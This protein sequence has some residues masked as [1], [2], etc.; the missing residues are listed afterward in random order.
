M[1]EGLLACYDSGPAR[2]PVRAA[3]QA[4]IFAF[5]AFLLGL[6][7]GSL[8]GRAIDRLPMDDE[9]H[10]QIFSAE[11]DAE[12]PEWW[13]RIPFIWFFRNPPNGQK[14]RW[15]DRVPL[16]NH[17]VYSWKFASF[18]RMAHPASCDR[19][20]K[21]LTWKEQIPIWSF[22]ALRG[23]CSNAECRYKIPARHVFVELACGLLFAAFGWKFG[24]TWLFVIMALMIISFVIG[25]VIDWRYQI[26]PDEV[27]SLMLL[28]TLAYVATTQLGSAA[29]L[30]RDDSLAHLENYPYVYSAINLAH[31]LGGILA[32]AGALYLF[33]EFGGMLARTD[34]MGGGDVKLAGYIGAFVGWQGALGTIF[35]AALIAAPCGMFL[36]LLGRGKKEG[37]FTKFA[38]GPYLCMGAGLI[39]Y[40]GH[41]A[42]IDGYLGINN[43]IVALLAAGAQGF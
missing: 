33:A 24:A 32:G 5:V 23:R 13:M 34:A 9:F 19:C 26:I 18:R 8:C 40:Y 2:R 27:N 39:L 43:R 3:N 6:A 29:G 30:L 41:T 36:L 12:P 21:K 20:K 4:M 7:A 10:Y 31:G 15:F 28:L 22:F 37:G 16:L 14:M 17:F 35:Y 25:S 38:F 1:R 42:M 11:D